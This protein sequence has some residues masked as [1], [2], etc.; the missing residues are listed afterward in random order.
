M[1]CGPLTLILVTPS[2]S[3]PASDTDPGCNVF[4][5]RA[6]MF[7]CRDS[8]LDGVP[9][10][11]KLLSNKAPSP[12]SPVI[13][14]GADLKKSSNDLTVSLSGSR[15]CTRHQM[16][17]RPCD[18]ELC[19]FDRYGDELGGADSRMSCSDGRIR[20]STFWQ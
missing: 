1:K 13:T 12:S 17:V 15:S 2:A 20:V 3:A 19:L 7:S 4:S 8:G 9:N 5:G 16:T 18:L 6:E 11:L 10:W 14:C